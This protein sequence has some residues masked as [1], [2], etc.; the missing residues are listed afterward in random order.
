MTRIFFND[1][2]HRAGH[3]IANVKTA[4]INVSQ[5]SVK[6]PGTVLTPAT[7]LHPTDG[8]PLDPL[9]CVRKLAAQMDQLMWQSSIRIISG[10]PA[11]YQDVIEAQRRIYDVESLIPHRLQAGISADGKSLE[12]VVKSDPVYILLAAVGLQLSSICLQ[13]G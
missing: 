12:T 6:I 8:W 9:L 5:I 7:P 4:H 1:Y 13:S 11:T 2:F 10:Q 3:S